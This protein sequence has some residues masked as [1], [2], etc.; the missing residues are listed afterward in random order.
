[1][2]LKSECVLT[3]HSQSHRLQMYGLVLL[4]LQLARMSTSDT[5]SQS[6]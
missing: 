1:M 3:I 5:N 6:A 4:G 2:S